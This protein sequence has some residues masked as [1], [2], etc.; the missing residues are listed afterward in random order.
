MTSKNS[1][2]NTVKL[3]NGTKFSFAELMAGDL[4]DAVKEL[5]K[6]LEEAPAYETSMVL[7]WRSAVRGGFKGTFREFVDSIPMAE[8]QEVV[9]VATP[10]LGASP[11]QK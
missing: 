7:T 3:S 4:L 10:F 5:G 8:V 11:S 2:D 6:A 1:K 9:K